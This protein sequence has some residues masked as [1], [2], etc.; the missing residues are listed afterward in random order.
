MRHTLIAT[1]T[2]LSLALWPDTD[3]VWSVIGLGRGMDCF[4]V[5]REELITDPDATSRALRR[6]EDIALA[7]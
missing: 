3:G 5:G 7:R 1:N 4:V 2:Q 6:C